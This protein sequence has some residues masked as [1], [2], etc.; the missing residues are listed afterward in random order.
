M[1]NAQPNF[2]IQTGQTAPDAIPAEDATTRP[3]EV[4]QDSPFMQRLKSPA[5][6]VFLGA[7]AALLLSAI[8][9]KAR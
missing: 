9:N 7:A 4:C 6:L 2:A 8:L 5:G 3:V 1:N